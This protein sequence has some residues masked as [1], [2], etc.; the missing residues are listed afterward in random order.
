MKK[1]FVSIFAM[2]FALTLMLSA[3]IPVS[4]TESEP[5][6]NYEDYFW[7]KLGQYRDEMSQKYEYFALPDYFYYKELFRYYSGD[8]GATPDFVMVDATYYYNVTPYAYRFSFGE[9]IYDSSELGDRCLIFL[10]EEDIV[11]TL[12]QAYYNRLE[13]LEEAF[14]QVYCLALGKIGDVDGDMTI[15]IHDAT[16]LQKHLA[17]LIECG[18]SN[19]YV[20]ANPQLFKKVCDTNADH[21]INVKD[22]TII[23]KQIA[24][25]LPPTVYDKT[26]AS[27][28]S[29]EYTLKEMDGS[30]LDLAYIDRLVTD[31]NQWKAYPH[32]IG[33]EYTEEFF[34]EKSLVHI[35]R[36]YYTGMVNGYIDGVY[37]QGNTLYV[38]YREVHPSGG[39]VTDDIGV[40]NAIIEI[41]KDQLTGI[42]KLCIDQNRYSDN[43]FFS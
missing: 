30:F 6:E 12:E 33:T 1:S 13:G 4:A 23:Q 27:A 28:D 19:P 11:Y 5:T 36:T 41:D 17:H 22:A 10:P 18:N 42:N 38:K 16:Y 9:Y 14:S 40:F 34:K 31:I 8:E 3:V 25:I 2:I 43:S 26:P 15:N 29:V 24:K 20:C 32:S 39:A 7:Q 21:K 37:R 35:Y